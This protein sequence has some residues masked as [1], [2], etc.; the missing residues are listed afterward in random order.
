MRR[1]GEKRSRLQVNGLIFIQKKDS[2]IQHT[3][4]SYYVSGVPPRI[5]NTK[6]NE[7]NGISAPQGAHSLE[8]EINSDSTTIV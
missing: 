4:G 6:K 2:F 7:Q 5:E 3:P 1:Q 8:N